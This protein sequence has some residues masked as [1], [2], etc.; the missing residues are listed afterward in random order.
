METIE[1]RRFVKE[2]I[3]LDGKRFRDCDFDGCTITFQGGEMPDIS[4]CRMTDTVWDIQGT[5]ANTINFLSWLYMQT[6]GKDMVDPILD[7]IRRGHRF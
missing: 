2:T 3:Q 6:G 1:G 7:G 5:A 4:Q